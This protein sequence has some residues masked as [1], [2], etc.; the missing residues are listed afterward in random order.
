MRR[1]VFDEKNFFI[2]KCEHQNV[3]TQHQKNKQKKN[4]TIS[5]N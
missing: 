4:T 1:I 3:V 2:K 5:K